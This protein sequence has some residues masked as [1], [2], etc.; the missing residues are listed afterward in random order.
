MFSCM[1]LITV[2]KIQHERFLSVA[3]PYSVSSGSLV[4]NKINVQWGIIVRI[5][6]K[7]RIGKRNLKA[8]NATMNITNI[9]NSVQMTV[10]AACGQKLCNFSVYETVKIEL[11]SI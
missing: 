11:I 8:K 9:S 2:M 10:L 3:W 5:R 6:T 1:W 4:G 7:T